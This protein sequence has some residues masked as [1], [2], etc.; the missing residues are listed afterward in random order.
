MCPRP[1]L[2]REEGGHCAVLLDMVTLE[3]EPEGNEG[4]AQ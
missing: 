1:L 2:L 3:Q 4:G